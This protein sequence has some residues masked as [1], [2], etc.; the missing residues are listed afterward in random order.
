M[1]S[2]LPVTVLS[3]FLGAGKT[4]LLNHILNNREGRRVAVIVNDMSEVNIDAALV[5]NGGAQLSRTDEK[6]VEMSNGC[7]C[8]TLREDLLMEV[9][10]LA[11]HGR[12]DQ[13][14]IESTGIS[15]PLPVAETFTFAD[16]HGKSLS[17]VARLDTMVTVVDAFNFLKDY[18][19]QDSLQARGESLGDEDERT[20]VDL[21]IEQIEFCDV[22][23]LNKLDLIDDVGRERLMA[24]LHGL[25]PR[26]KI[27]IAVFGKVSLDCVLNTHLFDFE[28]A[29]KAPG[30]LRELRGEHLSETDAYGIGSFVWRA[31][32]PMHPQ[33]FWDLVNSEWP[34]VL[35]SKGFFWLAS[36]PTH[37]GSWS[38][39]GAVCR[40]GAAGLWWAAVPKAH[41]PTDVESLQF[42]EDSW[43]DEV[44]DARQELVLIGV[45]MNEATL[46]GRLDACLLTDAEMSNG[47]RGWGE[48]FDPFPSWGGRVP[49]TDEVA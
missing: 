10:R 18:S 45:D 42:I 16:E 46:R 27:E 4:T 13:L 47:P 2:R 24:I 36:R 28:E 41:W 22:I 39:A 11:E 6:L 8:C 14:V 17:D 43:H 29:A 34:G 15:E 12:F 23:V 48:Y 44:G 9:T 21:L 5:R 26:A 32:R 33:R 31:R 35:R 49:K 7:I 1:D 37:A 38:Q 25:N 3:G 19:S 30:W 40:H 20:V